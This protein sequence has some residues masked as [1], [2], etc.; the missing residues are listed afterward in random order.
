MH[1]E[2]TP[3]S[4]TYSDQI[5]AHVVNVTEYVLDIPVAYLVSQNLYK[6]SQISEAMI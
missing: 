6:G 2:K 5:P 1:V 3:S 4:M